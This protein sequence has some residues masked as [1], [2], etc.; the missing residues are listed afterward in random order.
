MPFSTRQP[1][2]VP[3]QSYP[4]EPASPTQRPPR[5]FKR[6]N[7]L[8]GPD[9]AIIR[10]REAMGYS[11]TTPTTIAPGGDALAPVTELAVQGGELVGR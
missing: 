1:I 11:N 3:A 8:T 4:S 5:I 6:R 9:S 10:F 7:A 2:S